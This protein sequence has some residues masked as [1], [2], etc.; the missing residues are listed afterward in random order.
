M[1]RGTFSG[2]C[3][4]NTDASWDPEGAVRNS[5]TIIP[6]RCGIWGEHCVGSGGSPVRGTGSAWYLGGALC[7]VLMHDGIWGEHCVG[8]VG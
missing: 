2:S 7:V 1:R 5:V 6:M 8:S 4:R 3:V